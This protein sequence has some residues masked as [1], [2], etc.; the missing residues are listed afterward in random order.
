MKRR[1]FLKA[2][3]LSGTAGFMLGST[4]GCFQQEASKP[5]RGAL[6]KAMN[7]P[8]LKRSMLPDPVIMERVEMRKNGNHL[9]VRI[10][11]KDG[12]VGTSTGKSQLLKLLYPIFNDRIKP[13]F[14]GRDARD[15]EALFDEFYVNKSTYKWQSV[16]LW[17]CLAVMEY[18]VLDLLGKTFGLSASSMIGDVI[19]QQTN[20]YIASGIRGNAAEEE[21]EN[22][23]KLTRESTARAVKFRLGARMSY[24]DH[25][26]ERDLALIPLVRET[27]GDDFTLYVDANGSY[28]VAMSLQMGRLLQEYDYD[29]FEEPVPFDYYEETMEITRQLGIPVAGG[30]QERS[31]RQFLYMIENRVIDIPTVDPL[32]FGGLIRGI[33]V[34]RMAEVAGLTTAVHLSGYGLGYIYTFPYVAVVPNFMGD[35]EYKGVKDQVPFECSTSDLKPRDGILKIPDGPGFGIEFDPDFI[36][37]SEIIG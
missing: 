16:P 31:L 4:A 2:G 26:T 14:E 21:A 37:A 20:I 27:L 33:R 24:N 10:T 7:Q 11:S 13:F 34:A 35:M 6:F 25:S 3:L 22:L 17:V 5:N 15:F 30:E 36:K 23:L 8:V 18:A 19:R 29:F 12:A 1:K 9:F 32:L 28:D